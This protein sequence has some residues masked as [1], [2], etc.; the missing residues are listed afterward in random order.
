MSQE[1]VEVPFDGERAKSFYD[2]CLQGADTTKVTTIEAMMTL[3][4]FLAVAVKNA[5]MDEDEALQ[6]V[7][8]QYRDVLE[9]LDAAEKSH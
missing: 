5:G 3:A 7:A 1:Y 9:L 4:Y 6:F 8:K 2:S